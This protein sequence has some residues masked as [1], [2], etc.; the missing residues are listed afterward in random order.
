MPRLFSGLIL[1]TN[2]R[3]QLTFLSAPLPGARWIE[4]E[5]LHLSLRFAGDIDTHQAAEFAD[6]LRRI[7]CP[8][9]T[10]QLQGVGIFGGKSPHALWAGVAPNPALKELARRHEVAARRAGLT[11][12]SR[13]FTP[14][15]TLARLRHT[16][17][18]LVARYLERNGAFQSP[19]FTIDSFV[20]YSARPRTGGGPYVVEETYPLLPTDRGCDVEHGAS[21]S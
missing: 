19:T 10:L 17:A 5:H 9:F 12:V 20:L 15:I 1:P 13:R 6:A 21:L 8:Q 18:D 2:V 14:H 16:R 11:P 3:Q 7:D 4:N